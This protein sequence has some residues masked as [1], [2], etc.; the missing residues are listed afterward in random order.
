MDDKNI[1]HIP[2]GQDFEWAQEA[3]KQ[4]QAAIAPQE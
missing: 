4:L 1:V 2:A 3:L